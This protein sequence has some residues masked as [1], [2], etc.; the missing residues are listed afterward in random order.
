MNE[1]EFFKKYN[2]YKVRKFK[3]KA[4]RVRPGKVLFFGDSITEFYPLRILLKGYRAFNSGISGN[5]TADLLARMDICVYPY[6][7][8]AVVILAG[9]NDIVNEKKDVAYIVGNYRKILQG[10]HSNGIRKIIIQSCYPVY[11]DFSSAN[12][13]IKRFN[14]QLEQLAAEFDCLYL[15]MYTLLE[16]P[17]TG[18]LVTAYSK[19]GLH[20]NKKGYRVITE[21]LKKALD[22]L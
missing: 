14:L 4:R 8:C 21:P 15:D 5:T 9:G 3:R 1:A 18:E 12:E 16:D 2:E 13:E 19:D 11:G 17:Q 6:R 10:L 22:L 20:P 7:P